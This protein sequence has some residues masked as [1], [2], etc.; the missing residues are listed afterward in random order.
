MFSNVEMQKKPD[1]SRKT[2]D[3]SGQ[4]VIVPYMKDANNDILFTMKC[5]E[6]NFCTDVYGVRRHLLKRIEPDSIRN[7]EVTAESTL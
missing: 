2:Y 1:V 6:N 7:T 5:I 4:I 3:W